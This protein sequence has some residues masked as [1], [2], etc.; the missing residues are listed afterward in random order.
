MGSSAAKLPS[1]V[2]GAHRNDF[3]GSRFTHTLKL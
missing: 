3:E 2:T 1:E